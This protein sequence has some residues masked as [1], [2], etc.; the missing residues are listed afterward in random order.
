MFNLLS[1]FDDVAALFD[2]VATLTKVAI[3]DTT[4]LMSDDLAVNTG[5]VHGVLANEELPMVWK[6]FVGSLLNKVY[7]ISGV[8][9]ILAI[10]PP[11][12]KVV[13]VM[14]GIYLSYEGFHKIF[15][16]IFD[17]KDDGINSRKQLSVDQKV[18][19]A[20]RTDLI[21]SIEIIV[22]AHNSMKGSFFTQTVSLAVVGLLVSIIIYGLVALLV[23]VD[24]FGLFLVDKNYKK[25][26]FALVKS[27]PY[28]MKLLGYIGIVAMFLVGGGIINHTFHI[29][30]YISEHLQHFILGLVCGAVALL[31]LSVTKKFLPEKSTN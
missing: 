8:L 9:L 10:Y 12:L 19:G 2:D 16:K 30:L 26:G 18:K 21:L 17:K 24:D 5:V 22:I 4:A 31:A 13:L 15:E 7:S 23:K 3:E 27:M 28:M 14:G 20:V 11:I 1:L 6:I 25:L 29:P